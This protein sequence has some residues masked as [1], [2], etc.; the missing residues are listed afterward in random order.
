MSIATSPKPT[1]SHSPVSSADQLIE[2]RIVEACSA[3]WWAELTRTILRPIIVGILLLLGW[4]VVDQW[5]YSPGQILR[6]ILLAAMAAGLAWYLIRRVTPLLSSSIEPDYAA[7]S[8]EKD[9][10]DLH[11]D[12]TSYVTLREQRNAKSLRSRVV[13]SIGSRAAG[14]LKKHDV[15]PEE[16]TGTLRLWI[17]TAGALALLVAYSVVSPKNSVTSAARL[18]APLAEI[19]PAKRVS[20]KDVQPG[21]V[22]AI[23]GRVVEVSA[24]IDGMSSEEEAQCEWE[25]P[26]SRQQAELRFDA[27]SGLYRGEIRLPHS[28]QGRIDYVISAGD[29]TAGPFHLQ[30]K[31][32]PVVALQSVKYEPPAYTGE[33]AH[34]SS[35]GAIQ[36][37]D[38][39]R[40]A[41]L[42]STNRAVSKAKIEFNPKKIGD[43]IQATAGATEMSISEDGTSLSLTFPLKSARGRSAAVEPESY[44]IKVWDQSKQTNPD[45]IVYPIS[46]IA[47]LPPEISIVLPTKSPQDLPI[48]LQ[49]AIEIHASDPDYGLKQ[50]ALEIRSGIDLI[51]EPVLWSDEKGA[52]GNRVTEY[53]FRPT[54]HG[55]R[56]GDKV[57]VVA[58]AIDNRIIEHDPSVESNLVRSDPIE[59]RIVADDTLPP[60]GNPEADGISEPKENPK[61]EKGKE[62]KGKEESSD[63][64][65]GEGDQSAGGGSGGSGD[66]ETKPGEGDPQ[67]GQSGNSSGDNSG[68]GDNSSSQDSGG[69]DN[70]D[71]SD[72]PNDSG[73]IGS[74]DG[75]SNSNS[76]TNSKPGEMPQE[77]TGKSSNQ[78]SGG[79]NDADTGQKNGDAGKE[80]RGPDQETAESSPSDSDAGNVS[81]QNPGNT[82]SD[83]KNPNGGTSSS[84]SN[85]NRGGSQSKSEDSS[86]QDSEPNRNN[87]DSKSS[88]GSEPQDGEG[89]AAPEHDGDAFEKIRDHIEQKSKE[90]ESQSSSNSNQAAPEDPE[91]GG[92]GSSAPKESKTQPSESLDA[93]NQNGANRSNQQDGNKDENQSNPREGQSGSDQS[94]DSEGSESNNQSGSKSGSG[95]EKPNGDQ[96]ASDN[97]NSDA[98]SGSEQSN[99]PQSKDSM[100]PKKSEDKSGG[101]ADGDSPQENSGKNSQVDSTGGDQSSR[102]DS[103]S[104]SGKPRSVEGKFEWQQTQW[105][106]G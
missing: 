77:G 40:V 106:R 12:L 27:D 96:T 61:G 44:R 17:A 15:L 31:N 104:G 73:A 70:S 46:V 103:E 56:I 41:I 91:S 30:V 14:Q 22:E 55:L 105:F 23:A 21:D 37:L 28:A 64:G 49:Q 2:Q 3:L 69:G 1:I 90:R 19:A 58:V 47:D 68:K 13:R 45:P 42:A 26:A 79:S 99:D 10:P 20:I 84:E 88:D 66:G 97:G 82:K 86:G 76:G 93:Q 71:A 4:I 67:G 33:I 101:Q 63:T 29:A 16:A 54:R 32:A 81:Q 25:L 11:Q 78:N 87:G 7:R 50:V 34:T 102:S 18:V 85:D 6:I 35:S 52:K 9:L 24:K 36:G 39:T 65:N 57:Q 5:I 43:R 51:G 80:N 72:S 74:S 94:S 59:L 83:N 95:S 62:E 92:T 75:G 53:G 8:L 98:Q 100:N 38:G 48:N 89:D 60:E